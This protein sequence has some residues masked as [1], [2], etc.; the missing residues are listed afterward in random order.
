MSAWS[1]RTKCFSTRGHTPKYSE[2]LSIPKNATWLRI[3]TY[4]D[5]KPV[6][7][8]ITLTVKELAKRAEKDKRTTHGNLD[9]S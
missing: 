1:A 4:R 9:V 8:V 2:P 7:K 6:G 5:G 3:V